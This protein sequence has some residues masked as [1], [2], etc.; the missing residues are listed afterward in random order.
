MGAH[1]AV[2][3]QVTSSS[4]AETEQAARR[5]GLPARPTSLLTPDSIR[6]HVARDP[7]AALEL[8]KC[9]RN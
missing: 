9:D 5:V 2:G 7:P 6:G 3:G 8:G 1:A 4:A